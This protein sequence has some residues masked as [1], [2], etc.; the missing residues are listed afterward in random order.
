M[1]QWW[2]GPLI[3]EIYV[4]LTRLNSVSIRCLVFI[5]INDSHVFQNTSKPVAEDCGKFVFK[6]AIENYEA[7][8]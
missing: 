5:W 1:E 6:G 4:N 3:P 2:K 7:Q 8:Q